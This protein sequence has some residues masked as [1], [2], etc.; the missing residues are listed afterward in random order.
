MQIVHERHNSHELEYHSRFCSQFLKTESTAN[1]TIA[2]PYT[3]F[4]AESRMY[5]ALNP[6]KTIQTLQTLGQRIDERWESA[7]IKAA[8]AQ[9]VLD[10]MVAQ[11]EL[12]KAELSEEVITQTEEQIALR[13]K[14]IEE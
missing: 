1:C 11:Y 6:E 3:R 9:S 14:E 7:Q 10:Y 13:K 12:H 5:R 8:S 4:A 2:S